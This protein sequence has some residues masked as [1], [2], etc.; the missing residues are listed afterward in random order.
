MHSKATSTL[1]SF[2]NKIRNVDRFVGRKLREDTAHS[3]FIAQFSRFIHI[4]NREHFSLFFFT[5]RCYAERGIATASRLSVT[6]SACPSV[7]LRHRH[8]CFL[9]ID[10]TQRAARVWHDAIRPDD[11]SRIAYI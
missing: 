10:T 11:I 7:T 3:E 9:V 1:L 4:M 8:A 2:C 5:A 6:T